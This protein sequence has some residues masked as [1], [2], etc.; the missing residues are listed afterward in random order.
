MPD[1]DFIR[2]CGVV[3]LALFYYR[4]ELCCGVCY[5]GCL[6]L[7]CFPIYVSVCLVCFKFDCDGE[8]FSNAFAICVGVVNDFSLKVI[9]LFLGCVF[10][11]LANPFIVCQRG[12]VLCL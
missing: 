10:L 4:L 3:V 2:P 6:Q 5:V 8:L 1:V 12:C 11:L 7:E 9:V